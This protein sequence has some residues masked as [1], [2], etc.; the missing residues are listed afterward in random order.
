MRTPFIAANW[1]M[2]LTKNQAVQLAQEIIEQTGEFKEREVLLCPSPPLLYPVGDLLK[3]HQ[4]Y[5]LGAQNIYFEQ[6]G[7]YTGESSPLQVKDSGVKYVVIGHSERR[8][9]FGETDTTCAHKVRSTLE[10]GMTPIL[11]VGEELSIRSAGQALAV[12]GKQLLASLEE[13]KIDSGHQIVVAYEPIWAIGTGKTATSQDAQEMCH[14]LRGVLA[15]H[16]GHRISSHIRILYG[17]SVKPGNIQE[18]MQQ[19]DVDGAL[20]G[21]ASLKAE[22]FSQII[23]Y[24]G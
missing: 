19:A 1:K 16:F 7:A 5:H 13:V 3:N 15:D 6:E 2:H 20:V 4:G 22:S 11:C 24:E 8:Q 17:G 18:L 23:N 9:I 10:Q 14:H 21:G 12:V